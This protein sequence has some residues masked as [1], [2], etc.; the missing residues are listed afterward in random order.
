MR[1]WL[2]VAQ[3]AAALA[4]CLPGHAIARAAGR[5]SA[6]VRRFL[7]HAGRSFGLVVTI[8]G[9]PLTRDVL[10]VANHVSW[11][12][13]L[14]LGGATGAAFVSKDDVAGWP[15][16]GWL[17][18]EGGTIFIH[19]Q[20]RAAVRGQADALGQA[21]ASGRPAALFAEGTTG[22]GDTLLPFRASLLAAV[23]QA[24]ARLR[25]QPVAIDYG[26]AA[27]EIAWTG[28]EGT[29]GNARRVGARPGRLPVTLRFL[30][31]IDPAVTAGRKAIAAAAEAA[32]GG[33]LS[34][35]GTLSDSERG[36]YRTAP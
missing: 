16:V 7:A 24:P 6:W 23:E 18:R 35:S 36:A 10:Y 3:A 14:A 28:N 29:A 27:R 13:I 4:A 2:R 31:P 12:D 9:Q 22:P 30:A 21:L 11:L 32:I 34:Q 19:R 25:V 17:A 33:A 5:P 1:L 20:R 26:A 15:V 8:E